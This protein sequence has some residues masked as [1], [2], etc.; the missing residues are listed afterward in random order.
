MAY[1]TD[2][3]TADAPGL[4]PTSELDLK[5]LVARMTLEEKASL[6]SGQD[7]WNTKPVERL[8]I[9]SLRTSDGPHGLRLQAILRALDMGTSEPAVCFPTGAALASSW[10]RDLMDQVARAL[11]EE[12]LAADV[13]VLLGPG[14]NIKRSPLCG[15]NFE[16]FSEDPYLAS[17]IATAYVLGVQSQG[18]GTSLKHFAANNQETQRLFVNAVVD[19]RT[20]REIYLPNF[21]GPVKRAGPWTVMAAYN[22]LNGDFCSENRHLLT[23]VLREAWG[24]QGVVVTDWGAVN[25]RTDGL[26]AGQDLEMPYLGPEHDQSVVLAVREGRIP[27]AAL[28]RAVERLLDLI[29]RGSAGRRPGYRFDPEAHHALAREA[30]ARCMVLLRNEGN[31]LPLRPGMSVAVLGAFAERPRYQGGGSSHVNPLRVDAPL[32]AL[33]AGMGPGSTV[34]YAPGYSLADD[35]VHEDLLREAAE[36]ARGND[37]AVVFAG[38]PES[39]ESE[40]YDRTHLR[41]PESHVRLIEVAAR[42]SPNV[43]VVLMNGSPVEMPWLSR[44][45]AVLEGYLGG[46]AVGSA[47]ADVLLG[48]VNPGGKL[49]ETFPVRLEQTPSYVHFPGGKAEVPYGEGIFVGYRGYEARHETPLFPFGYGLSYTTFSYQGLVIDRTGILD[50][51][52]LRVSVVVQNT[53]PVAGEEVV[54]LY[55]HDV[56]SNVPRPPQ[57]LKGFVKLRLAPGETGTAEFVL[58]F[59]S[60]AYWKTEISEWHVDSGDFEIRVGPSSTDTPLRQIVHVQATR[61]GLRQVTRKTKFYEL[62][63]DPRTAEETLK[64]LETQYQG[65]RARV[66]ALLQQDPEASPARHYLESIRQQMPGADLKALAGEHGSLTEAELARVIL[67]LQA[68]VAEG[69]PAAQMQTR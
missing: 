12:C 42:V 31:V 15:R 19:E 24:F 6:L 39:Y 13:Q 22:Q 7:R 46:E 59:R 4:G 54:E 17:E 21:E 47:V 44:V 64:V 26:L 50:T 40:G 62:L 9:P 63:D 65:L 2:D 66:E 18:V 5:A 48:R 29:F 35:E 27:E 20:L 49:A 67:R 34:T 37:V 8:G 69:E 51:D 16:Y 45:R 55:V 36:A 10:D 52:S 41:M 53:G 30:A 32:E 28:D 58:D 61:P 60:F 33:R 38:L 43:V 23:E 14:V 68:L 57:E 11:G 56:E 1:E 3:R 25:V